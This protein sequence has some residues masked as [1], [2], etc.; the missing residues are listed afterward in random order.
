MFEHLQIDKNPQIIQGDGK[1]RDDEY[2]D[3]EDKLGEEGTESGIPKPIP[4]GGYHDPEFDEEWDGDFEEFDTDDV[5]EFPSDSDPNDFD[6]LGEDSSKS[7]I[8]KY[9]KDEW[10]EV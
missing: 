3:E 4:E 5:E 1:A 7:D 10:E 6:V 2:D 9:K 8:S